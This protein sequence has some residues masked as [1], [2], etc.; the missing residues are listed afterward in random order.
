MTFPETDQSFQRRNELDP[1]VDLIRH[2]NLK[3]TTR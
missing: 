3:L 1:F 2:Q